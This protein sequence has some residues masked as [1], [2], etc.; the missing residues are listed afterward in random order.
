MELTP[1]MCY[2]TASYEG[3]IRQAYLD[4]EDNWTW[5]IGLT[6]A[7]GIEP[8]NFIDNPQSLEFCVAAW[9]PVM[10]KYLLEVQAAFAPMELTEAQAAAALS[11]HWQTGAIGRA[12]W[13]RL[14][15]GNR[16]SE[17]RTIYADNWNGGGAWVSRRET[18]RDL[19]FHEKWHGTGFIPEYTRLTTS[20]HPVWSSRV[21]TDLRPLVTKM[22]TP[23]KGTWK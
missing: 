10:R 7:S 1:K 5:G 18:E 3:L 23:T 19:F 17:A 11:F 16:A 9:I 21:E 4:S 8:R 6:A 13:V 20:H 22:L 14:V 2:E 12:A 15:K